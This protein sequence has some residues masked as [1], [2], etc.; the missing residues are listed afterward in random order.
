LLT[1]SL[2]LDTIT[3]AAEQGLRIMAMLFWTPIL[4]L[5]PVSYMCGTTSM[6]LS[7]FVAAKVA[8]LP[9]KLFHVFIGASAGA[10]VGGNSGK[11]D[12]A[13]DEGKDMEENRFL[14]LLGTILLSFV[15]IVGITHH[16][17]KELNKV[18][19]VVVVFHALKRSLSFSCPCHR[20]HINLSSL[21]Q[22][23]DR[24]QKHRPG[25]IVQTESDIEAN[26]IAIEFEMAA[27]QT[28]PLEMVATLT[29]PRQRLNSKL[30]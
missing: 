3:A 7:S 12:P 28:A 26:E 14:I 1:T 16:I 24:Q 23:L 22:I 17:K 6:A 19:L 25:E 13:G 20:L 30:F 4:P 29:A 10:L 11:D 27:A 21:M 2:I 9:I 18:R 8:S 15:M 5:G